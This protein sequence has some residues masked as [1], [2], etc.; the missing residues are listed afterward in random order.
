[1]L[2]FSGFIFWP[3]DHLNTGLHYGKLVVDKH[4]CTESIHLGHVSEPSILIVLSPSPTQAILILNYL[5]T[6]IWWPYLMKIH[7]IVFSTNPSHSQPPN[8]FW[9]LAVLRTKQVKLCYFWGY[10]RGDRNLPPL[11]PSKFLEIYQI[12][13]RVAVSNIFSDKAPKKKT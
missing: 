1:M 5:Y 10:V 9:T 6:C 13:G 11:N 12:W 8:S 7:L 4:L 2:G 3:E